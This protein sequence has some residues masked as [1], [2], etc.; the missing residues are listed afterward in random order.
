MEV[1]PAYVFSPDEWSR[2]PQEEQ[3][4]LW[5]EREEYCNQNRCS[6][7]QFQIPQDNR[8][9]ASEITVDT[10]N[11]NQTSSV[12]TAGTNSNTS[13]CTI[14]GGCNEATALRSRNQ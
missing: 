13:G 6:D 4:Y 11:I 7:A 3:Q 14:I 12:V 1:H 2:M 9:A 8:S 10:H 5:K